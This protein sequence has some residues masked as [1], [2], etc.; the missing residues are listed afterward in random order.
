M[1]KMLVVVWYLLS[2]WACLNPVLS[3]QNTPTSAPMDHSLK[4]ISKHGAKSKSHYR[5]HKTKHQLPWI[6]PCKVS[7]NN[8]NNLQGS[9]SEH[10]NI[11][12]HGSCPCR[13]LESMV[14]KQK[15]CRVLNQNIQ[16]LIIFTM[17]LYSNFYA[18][19]LWIS[20]RQIPHP[21]FVHVIMLD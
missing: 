20:D 18:Q 17:L 8:I 6:I 11:S 3:A 10:T 21:A 7:A 16:I 2:H 15:H 14:Q 19:D 5:V 13:V 9:E 4:A 1:G 12:P